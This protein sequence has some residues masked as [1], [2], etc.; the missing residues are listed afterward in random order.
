MRIKEKGRY[1]KGLLGLG[2]GC[3]YCVRRKKE[4]AK[5]R[6]GR[7]MGIGGILNGGQNGDFTPW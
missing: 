7:G 4:K 1:G 3:C 6:R 5:E 2:V